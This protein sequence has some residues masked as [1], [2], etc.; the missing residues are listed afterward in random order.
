MKATD[1]D[2]SKDL[3]FHFEDGMTSFKDNR[4]VIFSSDSFGLL[5]QMLIERFGMEKAREIFLRFGYQNGYS[6]FMQMKINYDFDSEQ[7]LL[8]SGPVIHTWEGI[9]KAEPK[10]IRIDR[11]TG[12][13]YFS[14]VW[15]NSYEA[16]QHLSFN[17][18]GDDPICWS[19]EGYASGWCTGFFGKP[20]IAIEPVCEGKGDD[21]CEW[22]IKPADEFGDEAKPHKEAFKDFFERI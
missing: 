9:V 13:F 20:L 17:D 19:L 10:E 12:E 22:L 15:K 16:Q 11:E 2:F 8:A 5:R 18:V 3:K 14:G 6:D 7:D 1:F 4:L 21:H